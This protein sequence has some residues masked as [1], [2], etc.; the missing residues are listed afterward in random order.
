MSKKIT[1]LSLQPSAKEVLPRDML[2]FAGRDRINNAYQNYKVSA[3]SLVTYVNGNIAFPIKLNDQFL[4][5][6]GV[7][8]VVSNQ[9]YNVCDIDSLTFNNFGVVTNLTSSTKTKRSFTSACGTINPIVTDGLWKGYFN[10]SVAGTNFTSPAT[11]NPF[12]WAD[13]FDTSYTNY[14]KTIV[15]YVAKAATN[16]YQTCTHKVII[17]WG[18]T[19]NAVVSG[20]GQYPN[21]STINSALAIDNNHGQK[22][23]IVG[24][25]PL[26]KS[27]GRWASGTTAVPVQLQIDNVNKKIVKLPITSYNVSTTEKIYISMTVESFA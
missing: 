5:S 1:Q 16:N 27:S 25:F 21:T 17:Y 15:S 19:G 24:M 20:C 2:L 12:K 23:Y 18:T 14:K 3:E 11:D 9:E 22:N 7:E 6:P 26:S 4:Q 10:K 13:F 8:S